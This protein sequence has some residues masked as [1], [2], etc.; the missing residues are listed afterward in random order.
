MA[1]YHPLDVPLAP[2]SARQKSI[3]IW[4]A[5]KKKRSMIEQLLA[6]PLAPPSARGKSELPL[7]MQ[8]KK[9]R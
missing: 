7:G 1:P 3:A 5:A 6:V 4:H 8:K 2:P 9:D